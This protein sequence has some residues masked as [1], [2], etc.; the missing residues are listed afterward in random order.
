MQL[1]RSPFRK[2]TPPL[3]DLQD[4]ATIRLGFRPFRGLSWRAGV[5]RFRFLPRNV[6]LDRKGGGVTYRALRTLLGW[7]D[8]M[9]P[10]LTAPSL[11]N[12]VVLFSGWVLNPRL[13]QDQGRP[14]VRGH[15]ARG[16]AGAVAARRFGSGPESQ[17]LTETRS[18]REPLEADA[19][20]RR[21]LTGETRVR[22]PAPRHRV[23]DRCSGSVRR[24][25][26]TRCSCSEGLRCRDTHIGARSCH[27]ETCKRSLGAA[28]EP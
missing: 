17:E 16:P 19:R 14:L 2:R 3:R 12:A 6:L 7:I 8:A 4:G 18:A 24:V 1:R 22:D 26:T 25:P 13:V 27:P 15:L 10:A 21:Q 28:L 20:A 11:R 9:R 23:A 5:C